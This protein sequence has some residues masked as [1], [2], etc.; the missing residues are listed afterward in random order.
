[1]GDRLHLR[2]PHRRVAVLLPNVREVN[3][4]RAK[5]IKQT[6]LLALAAADRGRKNNFNL[7]RAAAA[8]A[9]LI[10]HCYPIAYGAAATE[11]LSDS[12]GLSLGHLAVLIFFIISGFFISQS[13]VRSAGWGDFVAARVLRIYP[14]L[15]VVSLFTIAV[16]GPLMTQLPVA[17]YFTKSSTFLYFARNLSLKWF[18]D[19]LPGVFLN[20][21]F[22][23]ATNGSLWTLFYEVACYAGAAIVAVY[24][25]SS[26]RRAAI[27]FILFTVGYVALSIL[28]FRYGLSRHASVKDFLDLVP[29]FVAGMV[30]FHCRNLIALRWIYCWPL[31]VPSLILIHTPFFEPAFL[32]LLS[33]LVFLIGF[34]A[35]PFLHG[36]NR[37]GDYSY[38]TYVYAFPI[39]Q[40]VAC[41]FP[42]ISALSLFCIAAPAVA[43][44]SIASWHFIE[45]PALKLRVH[46]R[47]QLNDASIQ[48]AGGA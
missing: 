2:L 45:E 44:L 8:A 17:H 24:I 9:V 31:A 30:F 10:S 34:K 1:M 12:L 21:P 19:G 26:M 25:Q 23:R 35:F 7:L 14:A 20:N 29:A 43:G 36:Y 15:M 5:E 16:I 39:Q 22:P 37:I 18:Q 3:L 42:G 40:T 46:F 38:G 4:D 13:F 11:P 48:A 32:P 41:V 6:S 47:A 27:S 28:D 33:Y